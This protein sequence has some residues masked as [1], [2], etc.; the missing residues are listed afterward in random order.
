VPGYVQWLQQS[1]LN[2]AYEYHNLF[3]KILQWRSPNERWALK[4]PVHLFSF[5]ELLNQY[6]DANIIH[7]HRDPLKTLPSYLSMAKTIW[8]KFSDTKIEPRDLAVKTLSLHVD[9]IAKAF[10]KRGAATINN[11]YDL[12]YTN[13]VNDPVAAVKDIYKHFDLNMNMAHERRMNIWLQDNP[14]HK[15]GKHQYSLEMFDLSSDEVRESFSEYI[16]FQ[17]SL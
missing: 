16:K 4:A 12:R 15:H 9:S 8:S 5:K 2:S 17:P 14:Q 10:K 3:L 1:N 6:P 7:I 11:L 13:L